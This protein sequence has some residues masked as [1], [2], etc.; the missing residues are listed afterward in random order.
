MLYNGLSGFALITT[1]VATNMHHQNLYFFTAK[2]KNFRVGLSD[3]AAINI[4]VNRTKGFEG[5]QGISSGYIA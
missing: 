1:R 5:C 4:A 3:W 2:L